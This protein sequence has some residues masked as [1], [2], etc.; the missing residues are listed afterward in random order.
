M[1]LQRAIKQ[2][3]PPPKKKLLVSEPMP[4]APA[5]GLLSVATLPVPSS[6]HSLKGIHGPI[7]YQHHPHALCLPANSAGNPT[8][9]VSSTPAP[10][11]SFSRPLFPL[12][13]RPPGTRGQVHECTRRRADQGYICT[14]CTGIP[15]VYT[16]GTCRGVPQ[17]RSQGGWQRSTR[18]RKRRAREGV[19]MGRKWQAAATGQS[20]RY[21]CR[22]MR[23]GRGVV[24]LLYVIFLL[25]G[26]RT[27]QDD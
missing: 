18:R 23:R 1:L 13:T 19:R 8:S 24:S 26:P 17:Y 9:A 6:L 5:S 25:S 12:P 21:Y 4:V 10:L 16:P 15:R 11:P 2:K 14:S 22:H 7:N 27:K 20:M 3:H